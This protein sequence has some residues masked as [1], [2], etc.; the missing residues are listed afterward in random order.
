MSGTQLT[1]DINAGYREPFKKSGAKRCVTTDDAPNQ[2]PCR[3]KDV[4]M[5]VHRRYSLRRSIF[6]PPIAPSL[7][8]A[9]PVRSSQAYAMRSERGPP[10]CSAL[11]GSFDLAHEKTASDCN[12]KRLN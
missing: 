2:S 9:P 10:N 5:S 8:D 7:K 4:A 12:P 1:V 3:N 11:L 6:V